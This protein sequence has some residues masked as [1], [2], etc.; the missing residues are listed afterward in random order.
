MP[1]STLDENTVVL[2]DPP[3]DGITAC[4]FSS[5]NALLVSSWDHSLSLYNVARTNAP[6]A[7]ACRATLPS[8]VLDADHLQASSSVVSACLDGTVRL[9]ELGPS[10][11]T[12][13]RDLGSHASAAR[14]A[15]ACAAAGPACV[16][17]G[18]WDH[19]L[20]LWDARSPSPCI[21]TYEQPDKVLS[22]CCNGGD[23]ASQPILIVATASRHVLLVDLRAPAEPVQRREAAFCEATRC[24]AMMPSGAGFT[25]GSVEGR[26]AVEYTDPSPEA[27]AQRY[28]YKAHRT[29]ERGVDTLHAVNTIAFHPGHG[30]FATG[31][32]DG[33]VHVWDVRARAPRSSPVLVESRSA[34][35]PTSMPSEVFCCP[36]ACAGVLCM[37][38]PS[39][40]A[41]RRVPRRSASA[42][43]SATPPPLRA[44]PSHRAASIS[45]SPRRTRTSMA[46]SRA[47]RPTPSTCMQ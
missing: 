20:K 13:P 37:R 35:P 4:R 32:C 38:V 33:N 2:P 19:T 12:P 16:V 26:V 27:Q 21:G 43:S 7:L 18:S 36:C 14:C 45:P 10:G 44:S 23:A 17:S 8:P 11:A 39:A 29:V 31:G 41:A 3:S 40:R 47:R 46:S 42:T 1:L 6:P 28:A 5:S 22:L 25:L 30:T 34:A 15:R 9:H 24:V